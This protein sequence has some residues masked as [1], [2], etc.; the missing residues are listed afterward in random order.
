MENRII[1]ILTYLLIGLMLVYL[2]A[3]SGYQNAEDVVQGI[4]DEQNKSNK[5]LVHQLD[6]IR[7]HNNNLFLLT[8][9]SKRLR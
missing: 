6:S 2:G 3:M 9:K 1:K 8:L 5:L 4:I 7:R